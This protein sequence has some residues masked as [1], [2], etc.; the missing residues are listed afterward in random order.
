VGNVRAL[1]LGADVDLAMFCAYLA[2]QRVGHRVFEEQGRQILEVANEADA[3]RVRSEYEAWRDGRLALQ[4]LPRP[5]R[6]KTP[7]NAV[8]RRYPVVSVLIG[9][10]LVCFPATFPLD[11]G[12]LGPLLPWLTIVPVAGVQGSLRFGSLQSA[13]MSGEAWRLI[14]PIFIHFGVA[15]L[16]FNVAIVVEF[17]RRIERAA[18]SVCLLVLTLLIAVPGNVVQFLV[19]SMPLFGGL[20]G[21]AYG[22]FAYVVVR[23]RFDSAPAWRVHPSFSIGVV[24]MLV[25]MSSGVTEVFG[26]YIA[27]TVHWVGLAAGALAAAVWRPTR[28]G[29]A[30]AV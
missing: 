12:S 27:N 6:V 7:W 16:L 8:L 4:W 10:A 28:P 3:T 1:T 25:L 17:G 9:L 21:V 15:H 23:G 19:K 20:S 11:S 29:T 26:L 13:L 24:V 14:T 22:L 2:Q 30:S 5:P 18:G